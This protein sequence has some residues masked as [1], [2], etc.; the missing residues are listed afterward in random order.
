MA[1]QVKPSPEL[2][3]TYFIQ[4]DLYG[5][6]PMTPDEVEPVIPSEFTVLIQ[7]KGMGEAENVRMITHRPEVIEN[8]KGLLVDFSIVSSSLNKNPLIPT[9]TRKSHL[10]ILDAGVIDG[11]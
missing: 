2:D 1:L 10:R 4:R 9:Y 11:L 7:N 3:L 8:V 5:D 6:N